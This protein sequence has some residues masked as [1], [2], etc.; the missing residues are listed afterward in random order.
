MS[1]AL[2]RRHA[3]DAEI[4]AQSQDWLKQE[5]HLGH[6]HAMAIWAYFKSKGWVGAPSAKGKR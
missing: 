3:P 2:D 4:D 5:Y 6:G 1:I